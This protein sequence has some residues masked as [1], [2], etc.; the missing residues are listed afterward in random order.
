MAARANGPVTSSSSYNGLFYHVSFAVEI[1]YFGLCIKCLGFIHSVRI[2]GFGL[3]RYHRLQLLI[4]LQE[5]CR[6][7]S[8]ISTR[9]T[10]LVFNN[11]NYDNCYYKQNDVNQ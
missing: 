8:V 4:F 5:E 1:L 11:N 7:L 9:K 3:G 10:N 2:D 6:S